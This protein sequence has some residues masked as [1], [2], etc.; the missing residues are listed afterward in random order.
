MFFQVDLVTGE[1]KNVN[2]KEM[3]H[4]GDVM[5]L[6]VLTS[7]SA[8]FGERVSLTQVMTMST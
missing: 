8:F 6:A 3:G 2:H 7:N 1:V 4:T 5:E